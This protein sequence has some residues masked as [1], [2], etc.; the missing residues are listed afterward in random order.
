[1]AAAAQAAV[2]SVILLL[3]LT[4]IC[5]AILAGL[6]AL[7]DALSGPARRSKLAGPAAQHGD[8]ESGVFAAVVWAG[9]G[10]GLELGPM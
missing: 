7:R 1:M 5:V 6:A 2:V 9:P 3:V 4:P 8:H 10:P